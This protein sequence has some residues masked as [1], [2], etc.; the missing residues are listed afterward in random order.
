MCNAL[1]PLSP[2]LKYELNLVDLFFDLSVVLQGRCL[3]K[4]AHI[5]AESDGE[6]C[7]QRGG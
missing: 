4:D 5:K 6:V 2:V 3:Q 1:F 7:P